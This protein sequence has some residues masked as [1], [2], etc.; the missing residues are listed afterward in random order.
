MD[1]QNFLL[2]VCLCGLGLPGFFVFRS[3]C[4]RVLTLAG[5][6]ADL[7]DEFVQSLTI[8]I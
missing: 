4:L 5:Q 7:G 1:S 3:L 2:C 6:L 8:D